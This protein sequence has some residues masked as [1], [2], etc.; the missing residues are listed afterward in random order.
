LKAPIRE[1]LEHKTN[2]FCKFVLQTITQNQLF[3]L[4]EIIRDVSKTIFIANKSKCQQISFIGFLLTMK[5]LAWQN[6]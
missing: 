1:N 6:V 3:N 2:K 5:T 4:N